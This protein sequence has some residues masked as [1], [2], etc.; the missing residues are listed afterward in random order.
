[1]TRFALLVGTLFMFGGC[2]T[3]QPWERESLAREVMNPDGDQDE[4]ALRH[5][6]LSAREGTAGGFGGGGGGC[7]CN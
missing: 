4:E 2:A 1:V 6:V 7:G 5:H 3:T